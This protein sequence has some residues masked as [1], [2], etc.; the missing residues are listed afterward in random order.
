MMCYYAAQRST[1]FSIFF[2]K[3][4]I[5]SF[6]FLLTGLFGHLK[7]LCCYGS[8]WYHSFSNNLTIAMCFNNTLLKTPVLKKSKTALKLNFGM[9]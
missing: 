3:E 8:N 1:E 4:V 6:V 2:P 9:Q 5:V 7:P